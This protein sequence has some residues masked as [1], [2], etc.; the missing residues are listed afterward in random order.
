MTGW[1]FE[2][3]TTSLQLTDAVPP[4]F[5]DKF[6][7]I[8]GLIEA[9]NAYMI[10]CFIPG[11]VS[12]LDEFISMWT[13]KWTCPGF[14]YILRKPHP[15]GNE[16]YSICCDVSEIMYRIELVEGKDEP[17][18]RKKKKFSGDGKTAGLLL[19]W[20]GGIFGTSK[21]VILDWGF[22][23]LWAWVKLKKIGCMRLHW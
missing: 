23:V 14:M 2:R 4:L 8:K 22:C 20:C 3:I 7:E 15:M 19:R 1:K 18:Q 16:Y 17:T 13:S 12:C 6:H 5:R 9:W 11:R 10:D 21:V